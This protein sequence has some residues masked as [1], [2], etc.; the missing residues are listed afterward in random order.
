MAG[1]DGATFQ[2]IAAQFQD[3]TVRC[4][5]RG[6]RSHGI[7]ALEFR[8]RFCAA[9]AGLEH[10][11]D[12]EQTALILRLSRAVPEEL[13]A[14]FLAIARAAAQGEHCPDD[15]ELARIYGTSSLGR[16]RRM[17][18]NLEKCGA[19]VVRTDFGGRRTVSIPGVN[20]TTLAA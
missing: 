5:M 13:L 9:V 10:D 20:L 15:E 8:R 17:L 3:F 12:D 4:R 2:P 14:P 19:I 16:V 6:I 7:D 1:E 18:D 11:P